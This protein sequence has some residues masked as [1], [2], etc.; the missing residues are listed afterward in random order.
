MHGSVLLT[1]IK[2]QLYRLVFVVDFIS[3][4]ITMIKR[5]VTI[6]M[7]TFV[8]FTCAARADIHRIVF[9]AD[10]VASA[11]HAVVDADGIGNSNLTFETYR[12]SKGNPIYPSTF[13]IRL[14]EPGS[15]IQGCSAFLAGQV[16]T[17][18]FGNG[19]QLDS[20]GVVTQGAGN[21][22]RIDVRAKDTQADYRDRLTD[23]NNTVNYPINFAS[24]G[25][26]KFEAKPIIP[27]DIRSGEYS[28]ALSFVVTYN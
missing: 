15:S 18:Q 26:F 21:R 7:T 22:V 12:K 28:S 27:D 20:A 19:G 3:K 16:A 4:K 13:T 6:L 1:T 10:V 5:I 24:K 11:C 14:Y 8:I 9:N 2:L 17:L 25:L 23:S